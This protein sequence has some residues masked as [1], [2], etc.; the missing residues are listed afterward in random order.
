MSVDSRLSVAVLITSANRREQTIASIKQLSAMKPANWDVHFYYVD[1]GS[2]DGTSDAISSLGL[3][4]KVINAD[5]TWTLARS[6]H[7]AERAINQEHDYRLWL[8]DNVV[9]FQDT[10]MRM[11]EFRSQYPNAILVAQLAD[12]VTGKLAR[13]GYKVLSGLEFTFEHIFA[14]RLPV[15]L[16]TFD[17]DLVLIPTTV[18]KTVGAINQKFIGD[19]GGLDYGLRASKK[20][21][22]SL[23]LPGFFGTC[24]QP[25]NPMIVQRAD[26]LRHLHT[27]KGQPFLRQLLFLSRHAGWRWPI[28]LVVPYWRALFS[29]T[30]K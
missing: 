15:D 26:A 20:R 22:R 18:A 5:A 9:V 1:R 16:D 23:A 27:T 10:Y 11:E 21:I 30:P 13:G 28:N 2:S 3:T 12:P 25:A 14:E 4:I 19:F 7:E 6:M 8:N 29:K 24:S 17:G